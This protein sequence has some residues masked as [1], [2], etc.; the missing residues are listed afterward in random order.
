M[1]HCLTIGVNSSN[2]REDGMGGNGFI[3]A[4]AVAGGR[5]LDG[6]NNAE[7]RHHVGGELGGVLKGVTNLVNINMEEVRAVA[8]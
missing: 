1:C 3:A 6:L 2:F 8:F 7:T 5:K 4:P